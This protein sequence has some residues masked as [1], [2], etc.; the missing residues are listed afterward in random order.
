MT[1]PFVRTSGLALVLLIAGTA[2]AL[3]AQAPGAPPKPRLLPEFDV[4]DSAEVSAPARAVGARAVVSRRQAATAEFVAAQR[5]AGVSIRATHGAY[6]APKTLAREGAALTAA[7]RGDAEA[8]AR[9]F[10]RDHAAIFPF[11][12]REMDDLRLVTRD[13]SHGATF[14]A[15]NQTVDGVDVFNGHVKFTLSGRGEVVQ[16]ATGDVAPQLSVSNA[17]ALSPADAVKAALALLGGGRARARDRAPE[18][19]A[20]PMD[21]LSGRLAWRIFANAGPGLP[22][23][24]LVD[25]AD[26]SLLFRHSLSLSA[27]A[28]GRVWRQSPLDGARE[29]VTFPGSWLPANATVT[30]GNN[31]DAY[32]DADGDDAPD[33][34]QSAEMKDGHAYSETRL[35]DF[36]FGDGAT[37]KDPRKYQPAAVTNLFYMVNTAHD[38]YYGLGFTEAAGNFQKDNLG[39]GGI[40]GDAVMAAAQYGGLPNNAAFMPTPDGMAPEMVMGLFTRGTSRL[41]DDGDS[42]YDGQVI[43]HEYG[44][45]VS[46]R[47]VGARTSTSCLAKIQSGAMGEGW[48]DYFAAS[49]FNNPAMSSYLTGIVTGIRRQSYEGYTFTYE[50]IGN[51]GYE[52]H[53][54]GEIWAATLWDLR[55][56]LGQAVTDQLVMDGLKA[57]PCN[58]SMIDARDAILA[59]DKATNGGANGAAIWTVFARH[60]MGYSAAGVEGNVVTGTVY[61][62]AYDLPADTGVSL[63]PK[64][65]S[66]PVATVLNLG[67]AYN[68]AMAVTN[69]NG[70]SLKFE[71]LQGPSGMA[72]DA[73]TG[74]LSWTADFV[75]HRV[76]VAISDGKGGKVVHGFRL[77]VNTRLRLGQSISI[78]APET[79]QGYAYIDVPANGEIL[80]ATLRNGS[81]G[82]D[83]Y[84]LSPGGD[85]YA[86]ARDGATETLSLAYPDAGRWQIVVDGYKEFSS[87][88]LKVNVMAA[89]PLASGATLT[90]LGDVVSSESF[91]RVTVPEG[92]ARL[93]VSTTGGTGDVDLF[94]RK[95]K[96]AVCQASAYVVAP[97]LEDKY[98]GKPGTREQISVLNPSAGVWYFDLYGYEDYSSVALTVAV[99]TPPTLAVSQTALA[100][101][102]V[103]GAPAPASKALRITNLLGASFDWTVAASTDAGG[104]W[105]AVSPAA[106]QSDAT[107]QIT[108]SQAGLTP[109]TY[110]GGAVVTAAGLVRSPI[111]VPVTLTVLPKPALAVGTPALTF[112]TTAG[113]NPPSQN[114]PISTGATAVTWSATAA[115]ES[116]GSWLLAS[117]VTGLGQGSVQVAVSALAL[118]QGTYKGTI[119]IASANAPGQAAVAQVTLTVSAPVALAPAISTGGVSGAGASAPLITAISPGAFVSVYGSNF[120]PSGTARVVQQADMVGG[121]LPTQLAGVCVDVDGLAAFITFVSP[122]QVNFQAPNVRVGATV[123]IVVK[124]NCGAAAEVKSAPAPVATRAA[125]PEFLYWTH[126]AGGK[127]PVVAVNAVTYA[128]AGQPGLIP[129]LTFVPAKPGDYVTI[130]GVSF[131]PTTPA[132]PPGAPL[133]TIAWSD[134]ARSVQLGTSTLAD[135]DL[136][137]VGASPGTAGLYQLNIR[138]PAGLA[139]GNYPVTLTLGGNST[140]AGYLTV[141]Q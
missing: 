120:A 52:V 89:T 40:S 29:L 93:T 35:F 11:S 126:P 102:A 78:S 49:F 140:P 51:A 56:S 108:A 97:C 111:T 81:G 68:Y 103:E 60:G 129:G 112:Q 15:F 23:E 77:P 50:D 121:I 96:P 98:S 69:P 90:D 119:T 46:N 65:T 110:Q 26:G 61:N 54:D 86:S 75:A 62:A 37:G 64:I 21:A 19:V 88:D 34:V 106:G 134:G 83:L 2:H 128:Y 33:D 123:N 43:V 118:T 109:G 41:T 25:A 116:G 7:S 57:T 101:E 79:F 70:G 28:Q 80:Q 100:F 113:V 74:A 107:V 1:F 82:P 84:L 127:N 32:L 94:L 117:P 6:G 105:L 58:P 71:M 53:R 16:V 114:L 39:R 4:R 115:T 91:F 10:L 124:T 31:V 24:L 139:A 30:T 122:G 18:L 131:G 17:V 48:S 36:E 138:V 8:I 44:H 136:L 63:N 12:A 73:A 27:D 38:Y 72:M 47:L 42:D 133:E 99:E 9:S 66:N 125:T 85:E 95:D 45:G 67:D 76:K 14:L 13:A 59:A 3:F 22:Y 132:F 92:A 55:K 104:Q 141:G 135:A 87:V 130:Y 20:F 137:Y 5:P